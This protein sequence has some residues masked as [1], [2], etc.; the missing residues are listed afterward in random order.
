MIDAA[1]TTAVQAAA[2]YLTVNQFSDKHPAF[3]KGGLRALIFN[4]DSNGLG[5]AGAVVRVGR[6]VLLHEPRFFGWIESQN[7]GGK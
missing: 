7:Q 6:K 5:D 3:T 2:T 4:E 1:P